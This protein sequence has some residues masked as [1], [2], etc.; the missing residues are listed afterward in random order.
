[1]EA[2]HLIRTSSG[3]SPLVA[4]QLRAIEV[5]GFTPLYEVNVARGWNTTPRVR[6]LWPS[7]ALARWDGTDAALWH[8]VHDTKFVAGIVGDALP[9][10]IREAEVERWLNRCDERWVVSTAWLRANVADLVCPFVARDPETG[11]PG[12]HLQVMSGKLENLIGECIEV[13]CGPFEVMVTIGTVILGVYKEVSLPY[14][15]FT[16]AYDR[17]NGS[18]TRRREHKR[19]N[20]AGKLVS[21]LRSSRRGSI[22]SHLVT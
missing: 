6:P 14:T 13:E 16:L 17:K 1:M 5:R 12:D 7:W 9:T 15:A 8:R 20:R 22:K 11:T 19:G 21:N 3:R 18:P 4:E 10:P 2:W